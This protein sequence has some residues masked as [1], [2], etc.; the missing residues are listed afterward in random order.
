MRTLAFYVNSVRISL[1]PGIIETVETPGT[2]RCTCAELALAQY[3]GE[4]RATLRTNSWLLGSSGYTRFILPVSW[5][6]SPDSTETKAILPENPQH[7]LSGMVV[8]IGH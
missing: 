1:T 4:P 3:R 7:P 2:E 5:T 6:L 8:I